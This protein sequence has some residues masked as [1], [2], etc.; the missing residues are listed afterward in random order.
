MPHFIPLAI[1]EPVEPDAPEWGGDKY[2]AVSQPEL[3]TQDT[4]LYLLAKSQTFTE[5]ETEHTDW[6]RNNLPDTA[7]GEREANKHMTEGGMSYQS[8]S[9]ARRKRRS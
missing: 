3:P 4:E 9:I 2:R 7:F 1:E 5:R 6:V 8:G